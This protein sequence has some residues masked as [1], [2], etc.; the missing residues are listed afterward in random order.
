MVV[1]ASQLAAYDTIKQEL[2]DTGG[3]ADRPSTHLFAGF[4]AGFVAS[5]TTNPLDVIKTRVMNAPPGL[6]RGPIDCTMRTVRSEGP[7]ALYK[8]FVPTFTRQAPYVI[9]TFL[10]LEQCK[11]AW[12]RLDGE[13]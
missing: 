10:T 8:G 11:K 13:A 6:Y 4:L 3:F 9:V 5:C 1:T 7:L 2:L 12:K